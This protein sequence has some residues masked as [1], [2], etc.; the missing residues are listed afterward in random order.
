MALG[1]LYALIPGNRRKINARLSFFS[2]E[3]TIA[4]RRLAWFRARLRMCALVGSTDNKM[5]PGYSSVDFFCRKL[6]SGS[7]HLLSLQIGRVRS[8]GVPV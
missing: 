8:T 1:R 6:L 3:R 4:V 5:N 7:V 2:N